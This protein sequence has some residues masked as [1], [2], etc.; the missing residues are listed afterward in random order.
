MVI[1]N[2]STT[3]KHVVKNGIPRVRITRGSTKVKSKAI[4]TLRQFD[5]E[6]IK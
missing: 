3:A 4:T 5:S 1:V 2:V 6:S